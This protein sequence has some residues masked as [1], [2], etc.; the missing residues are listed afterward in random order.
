MF[1]SKHFYSPLITN[2]PTELLPWLTHKESLTE[3]LRQLAGEAKLQV[4]SQKK[5]MAGWWERYVLNVQEEWVI[6]RDILMQACQISCWYARTIIP[7]QVFEAN[8]HFFD[9][10]RS[11]SLGALV[12][13]EPEITRNQFKYYAIDKESLEFYWP[14]RHEAI[15]DDETLWVRWSEFALNRRFSFYL[16]EILL[17]GL[18]KVAR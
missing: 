3:K 11:E 14:K 8:R 10:L 12:F 13:H 15:N 1:T 16:A 4:L 18:L 6:Q 17:P 2:P 9:R 5:M 7:E